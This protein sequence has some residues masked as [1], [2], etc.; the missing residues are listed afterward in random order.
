MPRQH[1]QEDT[2]NHSRGGQQTHSYL[3]GEMALLLRG[4]SSLALQDSG[5]W[6]RLAGSGGDTGAVVHFSSSS[7][8]TC[9]LLGQQL[10]Q[11]LQ[12][13]WNRKLRVPTIIAMNET[14]CRQRPARRV[15]LPSLVP[16]PSEPL[17]ELLSEI[18]D[19]GAQPPSTLSKV[20]CQPLVYSPGTCWMLLTQ[21]ATGAT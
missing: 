21:P 2:Y 13:L 8:K 15:L 3:H 20:L 1:A 14:T 11:W 9:P 19:L 4:P 10:G 16:S 6:A 18:P 7:G 12:S 5:W 17:P